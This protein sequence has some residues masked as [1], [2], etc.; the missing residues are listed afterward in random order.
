LAQ[1]ASLRQYIGA[2]Q[3]YPSLILQQISETT[4]R[5]VLPFRQDIAYR[6]CFTG[7][8]T[9]ILKIKDNSK[10]KREKNLDRCGQRHIVNIW[11]LPDPP[12]FSLTTTFNLQNKQFVSST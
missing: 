11:H 8:E 5:R 3:V 6:F 7:A 1:D 2:T 4:I 9:E 10:I 12:S